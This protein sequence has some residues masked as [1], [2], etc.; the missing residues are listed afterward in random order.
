VVSPPRPAGLRQPRRGPD[1][2]L[3]RKRRAQVQGWQA[4]LA[5]PSALLAVGWCNPE[6]AC[7]GRVIALHVMSAISNPVISG[8]IVGVLVA[9]ILA[10]ARVLWRLTRVPSV[11]SR[12]VIRRNYLG[13]VLAES[14][15]AS[16]QR[17][18][19]YA[20]RLLPAQGVES[21]ASIQSAWD[22]INQRGKVRVLTLDLE[23]SLQAGAELMERGIEVKVLPSERC[24]GS[25]SLTFHLFES[26][27]PDQTVVI[28]NRHE[29]GADRPIRFKGAAPAEVLRARFRTEWKSARPLESV[30]AERI[31]PR[32][33]CVG[34]RVVQNSIEQAEA[35]G[36][37]LGDHSREKISPHLA[38]HDCC[39]YIFLVG[40]PGAG[41][42]YVRRRLT[43]ELAALKIECRSLSDYPYAYLD[44]L[45]CLLRMSS[46]VRGFTAHGA[47][48]FA[49]QSEKTLV[50]ALQAMR[51]AI[52]DNSPAK[53]VTLIEFARADIL[54]ALQEYDD[55]RSQSQLIYVSAQAKVREE[56]LAKRAVP[57]EVRV[58]GQQITINLSDNHLL[59]ISAEH[60][61]YE[62]DNIE[63]VKASASWRH[64][65]FEIDNELDG[66]IHVN[67]KIKEFI[68]AIIESYETP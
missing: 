8:V 52:R 41:K 65:L 57:P 66:D 15:R 14:T 28:I 21:I 4:L 31:L 64:K 40:L 32:S 26:S 19:V 48:A 61:L 13:A 54:A 6:S 56:R 58:E 7:Y 24:L 11:L 38:F 63:L 35:T 49:V 5:Q 60:G 68:D 9:V 37:R 16:V 17:L 18:D 30:V 33:A 53:D 1:C 51:A 55:I 23:E 3:W 34:R 22:R 44:F 42:S 59:P 39:R 29:R 27:T 20:P 50:P 10:S 12:R 67:K 36:L 25:D 46:P 45:R 47:G 2:K 62:H 43:E